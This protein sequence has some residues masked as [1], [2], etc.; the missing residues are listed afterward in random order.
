MDP[1]IIFFVAINVLL[2]I[3]TVITLKA[4]IITVPQNEV[5]VVERFGKYSKTMSAGINFLMPY[6]DKISHKQSLKEQAVD[7]PSQSAITKDNISISVDGV[8]YFRIVDPFKASYGIEDYSFAVKQLAQTTMRSEIGKMEL[9]KSF[10]ERDRLNV[11]IVTSINEAAEPWGVSVLR[12][13]IKD[14]DPPKSVMEAMESQMKAER[15]RRAKILESEGDREAEINRAEGMKIAQVLSAEAEREE[16]VLRAKGEAAAIL[17][18]AHAQ[19]LALEKVGVIASTREGQS[20]ITLDLATKAI[21]AKEKIAGE[22]SVI[23][24]PD[25]GTDAAS[26]VAQA[27]SIFASLNGKHAMNSAVQSEI[28]SLKDVIKKPTTANKKQFAKELKSA[29]A[30]T[31]YKYGFDKLFG[32]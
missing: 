32:R 9:D 10:E 16:Q 4:G 19:S 17:E 14:I 8:L 18:V 22:S 3:L 21:Q 29:P 2:V 20:A 1:T 31:Y 23:L 24:L 5:Y 12:Y 13:E 25:G 7:V 6:V 15:E 26:M 30:K 11:S 28:A 27:T